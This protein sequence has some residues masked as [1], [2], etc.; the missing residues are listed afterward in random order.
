MLLFLQEK[1]IRRQR[2]SS[3]CLAVHWV[4]EGAGFIVCKV[5][6]IIG[7]PSHPLEARSLGIG[8]PIDW[9]YSQIQQS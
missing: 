3:D 2:Q 5:R 8:I 9:L 7:S 1:R 4:R 6:C